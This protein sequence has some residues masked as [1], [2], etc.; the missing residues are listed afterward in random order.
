MSFGLDYTA[1]PALASMKG[2]SVAFVCRYVGYFSGY[3]LN[4]IATAQNKV[5]T[6]GEAQQLSQDG[7]SIISNYEWY[8]NRA[9]ENASSGVWDAQTAQTIHAACGGPSDR[10][11]YFSVDADVPG[12]STANYFR[13]VASVIGLARTGAYGSYQVIQYLL[14]NNLISWAWQTEAWSNGLWDSRNHIEQYQNGVLMDGA[15]VDYNRSLKSDF[16]QWRIGTMQTYSPQSADF[17]QWFTAT[18]GSHWLCKSTGKI[19]QY[20]VRSFYAGLSTDGQTLPIVGLPLSN[21]L[22][23]TINGKSVVLQIFERA[24]IY[25]DPSHEVDSQ[26]GT[27]VYS[28]CHLNDA[29]LLHNIPGLPALTTTID[30]API[31][32][33]LKAL[34][35][36]NDTTINTALKALGA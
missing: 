1:G 21:E 36:Y 20:G 24:G 12:A 26:P 25:Y 16:G 9:T 28:L 15:S 23:L 8:A 7:I 5:L 3:N 10:P 2:A 19:V 29:N 18:D 35:T 11:I 31:I 17:A 13:G 32:T 6:P 34:Q 14:D 30:T 27:G 33:A 22:S 4:A